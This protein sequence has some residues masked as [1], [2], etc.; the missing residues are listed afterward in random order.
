MNKLNTSNTITLEKDKAVAHRIS[1]GS[2]LIPAEIQANTREEISKC[3]NTS[4]E[5]GYT[6]DDEGIVNN[7]ATETDISLANY[8]SPEQQKR[9][10][11]WGAGATLL[12]TV[13]LLIAFA[14]S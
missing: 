6:I 12:I 4:L 1:D 8:P 10:F 14:V 11:F 7:Y 13:T 2:E 9:Y 5:G 3:L